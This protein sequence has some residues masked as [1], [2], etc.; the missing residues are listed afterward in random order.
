[1]AQ[2]LTGWVSREAYAERTAQLLNSQAM[3]VDVLEVRGTLCGQVLLLT[4]T[5]VIPLIPDDWPL[6]SMSSILARSF[7]RTL[8]AKH[9][10]QIVKNISMSENLKVR[11]HA[12]SDPSLCLNYTQVAEETWEVIRVQDAIIEED[13]SDDE[14]VF[15]EK[16]PDI[17][18]PLVHELHTP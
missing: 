14:K 16:G 13:D 10:G 4:N 12:S 2:R 5:Q 11:R 18:A 17:G 9:E 6:G 8:H 3:N 15:D 1:V 7:R